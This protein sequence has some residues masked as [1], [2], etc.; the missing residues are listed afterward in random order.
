MKRLTLVAIATFAMLFGHNVYSQVEFQLEDPKK[1][2]DTFSDEALQALLQLTVEEA[3][4]AI[5]EHTSEKNAI[6][7]KVEPK[8]RFRFESQNKIRGGKVS[9]RTNLYIRS[10]LNDRFILTTYTVVQNS[11]GEQL[12]GII[13]TPR[14]W[15]EI[16]GTLGIETTDKPYRLETSLYLTKGRFSGFGLYDWGGS[17]GFWKFHGQV[18]LSSLL[19]ASIFGR[20]YDGIGPRIDVS[21][22]GGVGFWVAGLY[23]TEAKETVSLFALRRRF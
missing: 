11:Y 17:G 9:P 10:T 8:T 6:D 1:L 13:Y 19:S 3:L 7:E 22:P 14:S 20:R 12:I 18:K 21:L 15:I 23:N 2:I 4:L 5:E 16:E